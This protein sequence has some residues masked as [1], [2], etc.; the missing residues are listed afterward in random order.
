MAGLKCDPK[1]TTQV[2]TKWP[3]PVR[4]FD[5][6]VDLLPMQTGKTYLWT[7]NNGCNEFSQLKSVPVNLS[8]TN[9]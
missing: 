1:V 5:V 2:L 7:V 6:S 4:C 3:V 8:H 9:I